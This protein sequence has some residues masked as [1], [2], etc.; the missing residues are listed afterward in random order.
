MLFEFLPNVPPDEKGGGR[1]NALGAFRALA[2]PLL[3]NR[4]QGAK[5]EEGV[6]SAM[7]NKSE[8]KLLFAGFLFVVGS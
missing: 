6:K 5:G 8:M 7:C 2:C 1:S 4:K 3:A